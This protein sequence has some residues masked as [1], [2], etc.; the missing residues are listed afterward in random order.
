MTTHPN[1]PCP[2]CQWVPD[3]CPES[4]RE[5]QGKVFIDHI[6]NRCPL[7]G[8]SFEVGVWNDREEPS[9]GIIEALQTIKYCAELSERDAPG[10]FRADFANIRIVASE[11][12]A[13]IQTGALH[14]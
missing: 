6:N 1:K 3:S 14:D 9:V 11:T 4:F 10:S 13:A 2:W 7:H 5:F 8:L 12:L